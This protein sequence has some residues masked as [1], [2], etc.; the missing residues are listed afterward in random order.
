MAHVMKTP[1]E[2]QEDFFGFPKVP[3]VKQSSLAKLFRPPSPP[4]SVKVRIIPKDTIVTKPHIIP[5]GTVVLVADK[6]LRLRQHFLA[7]SHSFTH[8]QSGNA[9]KLD[10]SYTNGEYPTLTD[11]S[12]L[13]VIGWYT[14]ET[15]NPDWPYIVVPKSLLT[16]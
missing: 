11:P 1:N 13:L 7:N 14:F 10:S 6:S 16:T 9:P 3:Q 12:E 5:K 8:Y 4:D 15:Q 2:I